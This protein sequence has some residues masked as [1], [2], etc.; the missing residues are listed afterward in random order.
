MNLLLSY[1]H[2]SAAHFSKDQKFLF[3]YHAADHPLLF[4]VA[5]RE[6]SELENLEPTKIAMSDA[7]FYPC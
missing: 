6:F 1:H 2:S 5:H 4:A 7:I 3:S